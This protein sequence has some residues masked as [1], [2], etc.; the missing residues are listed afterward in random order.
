MRK[1]KQVKRKEIVFALDEWNRIE[2]LAAEAKLNTTEYIRRMALD[3]R[4]VQMNMPDITHV[5]NVMKSVANNLNQLAK[6]AHAINNIYAEDFDKMGGEWRP[7]CHLLSVYL[8][9]ALSNAA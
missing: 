4:I 9:E 3:N 1:F 7:L 5:L 6:K 2:H 8:S